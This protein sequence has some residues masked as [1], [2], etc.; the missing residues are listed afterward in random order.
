MKHFRPIRL[1]LR[2]RKDHVSA[3]PFALHLP[4]RAV[5]SVAG[6]DAE[7]FL[8]GLLTNATTD[9]DHGQRRH[10]ALLTPQG[11]IIAVM[12]LARGPEGFLLDVDGGAAPALLKRLTLFRLR[13]R[14]A[15]DARADL[16]VF[17][18]DGAPDPRS[19]L[20]PARSIAPRTRASQGDIAHYHANRIAAGL[21]EM[22]A[23]FG[24]EDVFPADINMDL[25]GGVDFKKGCFVGQEV[26][27][28]MKRRGVARRRTLVAR[29]DGATAPAPI[30]ADGFE[31]GRLTSVADGIGLARV[32]IDHV[33]EAEAKEQPFTASGV[34]L[35]FDKPDWLAGELAA[36]KDAKS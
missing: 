4:H 23:D 17:A 14:V 34:R 1:L 33:A 12:L 8:N 31:V 9:I 27:S 11:K 3:M 35:S 30:L 29:L 10:A 28:R 16:A 25:L 36:L 19:V 15:I 24:A 5:I 6:L 2:P 26:V 7:P 20:A 13:A 32:R 18:F 22:G 21:A